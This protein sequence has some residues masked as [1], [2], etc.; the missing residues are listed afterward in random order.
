MHSHSDH[1]EVWFCFEGKGTA[2]TL[3]MMSYLRKRGH[4]IVLEPNERHVLVTDPV[5]PIVNFFFGGGKVD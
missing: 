2:P 5:K 1:S 4:F 3:K